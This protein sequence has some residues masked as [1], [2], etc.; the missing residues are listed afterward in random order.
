MEKP[1]YTVPLSTIDLTLLALSQ[2]AMGNNLVKTAKFYLYED[3]F[4]YSSHANIRRYQDLFTFGMYLSE[5][6]VANLYRIFTKIKNI[7]FK[8]ENSDDILNLDNLSYFLGEDPGNGFLSKLFSLFG[9]II[10]FRAFLFTVWDFCSISLSQLLFYF[11]DLYDENKNGILDVSEVQRIFSDILGE[12]YK[13]TKNAKHAYSD[14]DAIGLSAHSRLYK[15]DFVLFAEKHSFIL[16]NATKFHAKL[17]LR[18]LG[19]AFWERMNLCRGKNREFNDPE[20]PHYSMQLLLARFP[21][22]D[23]APSSS[24]D[25]NRIKRRSKG[26][27]SA[28]VFPTSPDP[29]GASSDSVGHS[30]NGNRSHSHAGRGHSHATLSRES[31]NSS[32]IEKAV[33]RAHLSNMDESKHSDNI[34]AALLKRMNNPHHN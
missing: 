7:V 2:Q 29:A 14:L 4:I 6:D 21:P 27:L 13:N 3:N 32:D 19:E 22:E 9:S 10:T 23:F 25:M 20:S 8:L 28:K 24:V 15:K 18:I 30:S 31:T 33:I 5:R 17:R 16:H 12:D 1:L 34:K 26:L 11:F